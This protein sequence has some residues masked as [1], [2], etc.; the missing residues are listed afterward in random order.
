MTWLPGVKN[1]PLST[2]K[3][4]FSLL[5]LVGLRPHRARPTLSFWLRHWF[6]ADC[7][8]IGLSCF[9]NFANIDWV[10]NDGF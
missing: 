3:P 5:E 10:C 8:D 4:K 2:K 9:D 1:A 6:H 7:N